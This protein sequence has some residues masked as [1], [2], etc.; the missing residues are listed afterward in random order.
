MKAKLWTDMVAALKRERLLGESYEAENVV[1]EMVATELYGDVERAWW[2]MFWSVALGEGVAAGS[3]D[4]DTLERVKGNLWLAFNDVR[5]LLQP[6][7]LNV[8]ALAAMVIFAESVLTPLAS[9]TLVS[10]ACIMLLDLGVGK[11]NRAKRIC[12]S[13]IKIQVHTAIPTLSSSDSAT[14]SSGA[15]P[16]WIKACPS[17]SLRHQSSS[18]N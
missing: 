13:L 4:Q 1:D 16:P 2:V 12:S 18:V 11:I 9:W 7:I 5:F 10:K 17:Y 3:L 15:F 8:H 6:S 14:P